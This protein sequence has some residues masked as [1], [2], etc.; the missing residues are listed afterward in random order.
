MQV[1]IYYQQGM[2]VYQH[3][4]S[5]KQSP[6]KSRYLAVL[7][8]NAFFYSPQGFNW[9]N[10]LYSIDL[11]SY[12]CIFLCIMIACST[13][14]SHDRESKV[15]EILLT[16]KEGRRCSIKAKLAC[17]FLVTLGV[18]FI[19]TFIPILQLYLNYGSKGMDTSLS[20]YYPYNN[21]IPYNMITMFGWL[22]ILSLLAT[23]LY[24]II[25][26][27]I[28]RKTNSMLVAGLLSAAFFAAP[29]ILQDIP[30]LH[31][32]AYM[33]PSF[34]ARLLTSFGT[35]QGVQFGNI[36]LLRHEVTILGNSIFLIL[37]TIVL[38]HL[39]CSSSAK[40]RGLTC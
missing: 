23:L 33:M 6:L 22:C 39:S 16:T 19:F 29:I 17:S 31:T 32:I 26:L 11:N 3:T 27:L 34:T 8:S 12:Y 14:F 40:E 28:T 35:L 18:W 5:M 30:F 25:I 7:T 9:S 24:T 36:A 1:D 2:E 21:G 38:Y 4:K 13:I 37:F 10:T 15:E 20:L